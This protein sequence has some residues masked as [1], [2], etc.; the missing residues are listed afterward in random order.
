MTVLSNQQSIIV[1]SKNAALKALL[2]GYCLG[3]SLHLTI[4]QTLEELKQIDRGSIVQMVVFDSRSATH[5]FDHA[6]EKIWQVL[7]A[8]GGI[9]VI[10]IY[11]NRKPEVPAFFTHFHFLQE[12]ELLPGLDYYIG[13]FFARQEHQERRLRERRQV[14]DRRS[15]V[16]NG[17]GSG[18]GSGG[19]AGS[20]SHSIV[21][22]GP[23]EVNHMTKTVHKQGLDLHLT[24]KEY[25]LF[26]LLLEEHEE[27]HSVEEIVGQLWPNT[28]RASKSDLYQY[29]HTLRKKVEHDPC[30][31]ECLLT[32]KGVGYQLRV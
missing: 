28:R 10:F 31:P 18:V 13:Q 14:R 7:E 19:C 17:V 11:S 2:T 9:P 1:I 16:R 21:T 20:D 3:K 8:N 5:A 26:T 15:S 6:D 22:M 4:L 25:E 24:R 23:F 29:I 27:I 32:V 12:P 30:Q